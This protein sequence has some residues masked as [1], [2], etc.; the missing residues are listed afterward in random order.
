MPE[1]QRYKVLLTQ[2]AR[3]DICRSI[4]FSVRVSEPSV[5]RWLDDLRG[6]LLG[7]RGMPHRRTVAPESLQWG[8]SYQQMRFG[9]YRVLY[10]ID[11]Q[12]VYVLRIVD[13]SSL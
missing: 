4:R 2:S 11:A 12:L 9:T 13:E 10:R 8:V 6:R 5:R 1:S 3:R 7:L